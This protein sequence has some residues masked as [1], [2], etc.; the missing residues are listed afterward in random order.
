MWFLRL[1]YWNGLPFP[2][3]VD[4]VLSE[5]FTMTCL[6]WVALHGIALHFIKL[7]QPLHQDRL[8]SMKG[9]YTI[10]ELLYCLWLLI[11]NRKLF[12]NLVIHLAYYIVWQLFSP[13][14]LICLLR[15]IL[16]TDYII[17]VLWTLWKTLK[18][19]DSIGTVIAIINID[20]N[21]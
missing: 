10:P 3:P 14:I 8:W 21:L 18:S 12:E 9:S 13:S 17:K 15:Y 20:M 4:H 16:S 1:E 6:S 2:A 11:S 7:H 5:L 19:N